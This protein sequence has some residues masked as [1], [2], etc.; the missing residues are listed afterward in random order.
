MMQGMGGLPG[1]P[2]MP[3]IPGA[4]GPMTPGMASAVQG[5]LSNP[6]AL[7]NML[8]VSYFLLCVNYERKKRN[9]YSII[10]RQVLV[11]FGIVLLDNMDL[12]INVLCLS[13]T[14][15]AYFFYTFHYVY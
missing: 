1:M 7:Q 5:M 10:Y 2:G 6:Q 12:D 15:I 3:N 8:Q 14:L 4:R 9:V 11:R 13:N